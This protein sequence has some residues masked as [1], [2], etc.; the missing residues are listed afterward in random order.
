MAIDEMGVGVRMVTDGW[1]LVSDGDNVAGTERL[2]RMGWDGTKLSPCSSPV[3]SAGDKR[4]SPLRTSLS[5][6]LWS[7]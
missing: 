5:N 3:L 1:R 7:G 4:L 2:T 6:I